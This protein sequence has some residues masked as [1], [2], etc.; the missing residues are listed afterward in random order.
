MN[1]PLPVMIDT[2]EVAGVLRVNPRTV[3]RLERLQR[4][5]PAI[6]VGRKSL[7][8]LADVQAFLNVPPSPL[9]RL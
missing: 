1:I 4:L 8:K 7:W 9:E 3:K 5:P 2:Q 6:K